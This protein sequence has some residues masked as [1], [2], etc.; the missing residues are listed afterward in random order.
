MAC[1]AKLLTEYRLDGGMIRFALVSFNCNR[2]SAYSDVETRLPRFRC[3]PHFHWYVS[4]LMFQLLAGVAPHSE[5]ADAAGHGT[6]PFASTILAFARVPILK[7]T[8][9][10]ILPVFLHRHWWVPRP[11]FWS[12]FGLAGQQSVLFRCVPPFATQ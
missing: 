2:R 8:Q 9:S 5:V 1:V 7:D 6:T 3:L 12:A 10:N 11:T 4:V